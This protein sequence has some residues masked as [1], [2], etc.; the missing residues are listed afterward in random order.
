MSSL[1]LHFFKNSEIDCYRIRNVIESN[2]GED[3]YVFAK[4]NNEVGDV[5]QQLV[6]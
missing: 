3:I 6:V 5:E 1:S 4:E 2:F